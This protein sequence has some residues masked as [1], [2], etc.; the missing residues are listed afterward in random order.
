MLEEI[1]EKKLASIPQN[2]LPEIALDFIKRYKRNVCLRSYQQRKT[3]TQEQTTPYLQI[4]SFS[5]PPGHIYNQSA[6]NLNSFEIASKGK[7]IYKN[8]S[9]HHNL[10]KKP[11]SVLP[12]SISPKKLYLVYP[13]NNHELIKKILQSRSNWEEGSFSEP[14][15][16]SFI[17]TP[18]SSQ[19]RYDRLVPYLQT[20]IANHFEFSNELNNKQSLYSNLLEYYSDN[21]LSII[22]ILPRTFIIEFDSKLYRSQVISFVSCFKS[23]NK[24]ST[25]LWILKPSGFSRGKGISIFRRLKE[26]K[27]LLK[28]SIDEKNEIK[29]IVIQKYIES[30]LLINSRKFDIRVWVLVTHE[31]KCYICKNGYLRTS[32]QIFTLDNSSLKNEFIH[33]TNNAIQKN[34]MDYGKFEEGNQLPLENLQEYLPGGS[35]K[36]I[37]IMKRM[38]EM[39]CHS[40]LSVKNKLNSNKRQYCFEIFGYDFIMDSQ[41]DI[42]LIE[43]NTN[44][45]LELSSNLLARIIPKM[46]NHAF[47]LTIDKIFTDSLHKSHSDE[48]VWDFLLNIKHQQQSIP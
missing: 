41:S 31:Y 17:W 30:P 26:F 21:K 33:L 36:F 15:L 45:C 23:Q 12:P 32:S 3:K 27:L 6:N 11:L 37:E 22:E 47:F 4:S 18:N 39:I 34:G 40:L 35:E 2:L 46:L 42:W 13:G 29:S 44:P 43:C 16:A 24:E 48:N 9:F 5:K 38:R 10:L 7:K 19:I 25:N 20:Q 1:T 14:Y 28:K 8:Y